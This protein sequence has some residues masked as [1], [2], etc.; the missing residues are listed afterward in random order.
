[1]A[2][3]TAYNE[4]FIINIAT[5]FQEINMQKKENTTTETLVKTLNEIKHFSAHF[6]LQMKIHTSMGFGP[7]DLVLMLISAQL[8]SVNDPYALFLKPFLK[9]Q[10]F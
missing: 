6:W 2:R 3:W 10:Q 5:D 8:A 4:R 9:I 7:V 1:M